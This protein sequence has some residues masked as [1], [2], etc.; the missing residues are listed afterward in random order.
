MLRSLPLYLPSQELYDQAQR[1]GE[2][3]VGA[4][5]LL[6][7]LPHVSASASMLGHLS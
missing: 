7:G 4:V 5:D 3:F 1:A 6:L 2:D